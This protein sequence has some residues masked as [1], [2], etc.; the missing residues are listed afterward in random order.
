MKPMIARR[1]WSSAHPTYSKSF[2]KSRSFVQAERS[3][4]IAYIVSGICTVLALPLD[5]RSLR[6][7]AAFLLVPL[8]S[9]P[10]DRDTDT[11]RTRNTVPVVLSKFSPIPVTGN[12]GVTNY[13]QECMLDACINACMTIISI[14]LRTKQQHMLYA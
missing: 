13:N 7:H 8:S 2:Q 14:K 5:V 11:P 1:R 4:L 10:S 12:A 3:L 6:S 9:R